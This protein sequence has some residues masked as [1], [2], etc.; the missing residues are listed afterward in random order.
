MCVNKVQHMTRRKTGCNRSRPVFFGFSIFRQ[1][2]QLATEKIQNLCN[3]NWWSSLLQLGSV[4]FQ[5]FFQSSELDLRTLVICT[6]DRLWVDIYEPTT[7]VC[8][9]QCL[10]FAAPSIFIQG[11]T[12]CSCEKGRGCTPLARWSLRWRPFWQA[13]KIPHVLYFTLPWII[14]MES[15]EWGVDSR[16]SRWNP[17]N[18]GWTP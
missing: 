9:P 3:R 15:M 18:G 5:S 16:N 13:K 2:S 8:H 7:E 12:S 11:R 6:E 17:W 1:T 10:V 14:H 4:R